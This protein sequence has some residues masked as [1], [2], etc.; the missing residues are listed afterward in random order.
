MTRLLA[1][2]GETVGIERRQ[3]VAVPHVRLTHPDAVRLHGQAEPE[4]GHDRHHDRVAGQVAPAGE[5][6][7][8]EGQEDVA[9]HHRSAVIDR[10]DAV[11]VAVEGQAE[12]GPPLDHGAGQVGPDRSTRTCR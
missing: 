1:A 11:G 8:E 9:V 6:E 2:E 7:G 4:V 5:V 3:H 10:D 12:V